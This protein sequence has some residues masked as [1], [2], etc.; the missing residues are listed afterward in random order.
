MSKHYEH[1]CTKQFE[2]DCGEIEMNLQVLKTIFYIYKIEKDI[3]LFLHLV[4]NELISCWTVL[5][6]QSLHVKSYI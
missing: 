6:A 3:V 2:L 4:P 1:A 5:I